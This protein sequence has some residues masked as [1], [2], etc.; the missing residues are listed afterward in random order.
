MDHDTIAILRDPM[1]HAKLRLASGP[2]GERLIDVDSG[3]SYAIRE[4]IPVFVSRA[5]LT[6][7]NQRFTKFYDLFAPVY[8]AMISGYLWVRRLGN[9]ESFR[10]EYLKD[11]GVKDHDRILEISI[12]TG[13]NSR[14]LPKTCEFFGV[15]ISWGMIKR[16]KAAMQNQGLRHRLF[17]ANGEYLPFEDDV[18]D[19][20]FHV[21]GIKFFNDKA[22]AIREMIRVA[23]PGAKIMIVDPTEMTMR[24]VEGTPIAK[25]FFKGIKDLTTAPVDLVPK[26]M[27]DIELRDILQGRFYCLQFRKPEH[28]GAA[29]D[30]T[31]AMR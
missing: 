20:V 9:D 29:A 28:A 31:H 13:R 24:D 1:T 22:R 4:G 8:D 3:A 19:A 10:R 23:K 7:A 15:D 11:L 16:C 12:G 30:P 21:G 14:Y 17:L 26:E 5:E 25:S 27:R 2:E 18:F 6:D